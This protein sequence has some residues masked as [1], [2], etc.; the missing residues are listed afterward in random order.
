M[1]KHI[2]GN[3]V[4]ILCLVLFI[5][6]IGL[7]LVGR[8]LCVRNTQNYQDLQPELFAPE[9]I[10][11]VLHHK[12]TK[13]IYVCYNDA[14]Y[15]NVYSQSGQFLWAVSTPYL[16][17]VYFELD[18]D[19]LIIYNDEAY[20]YSALDGSFVDCVNVDALD[21]L[22]YD[23]EDNPVTDEFQAGELYYDTYQVYTGQ[24]DG[25]LKTIVTRP[26]W[27][28]IFHFGVDWCIAFSG[29]VIF[30][31]SM[32]LETRKEWNSVKK[33]LLIKDKEVAFILKY[34]RITSIVQGV[35]LFANV[36]VGFF[37]GF[38]ILGII[39]LVL[40]FILSSAI[41]GNRLRKYVLTSHETTAFEYWNL[42]RIITIVIAFF[43]VIIVGV[44]IG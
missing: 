30:G 2:G 29:A 12:E 5:G 22:D 14:S 34:Y 7:G 8:S 37:G 42:M 39:P 1:K 28:W 40:H 38:L 6:G 4:G 3:I 35:Y 15:V 25:T 44:M 13:Q 19:K 18:E 23:W 31:I 41:L 9:E 17:N 43:S 36:L 32:F 26:W 20:I 16:R 11:T 27:Y 21:Y 24:A 10:A 33:G